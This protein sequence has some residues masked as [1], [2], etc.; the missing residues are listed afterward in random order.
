MTLQP[1]P[2]MTRLLR[3]HAVPFCDAPA[4]EGAGASRSPL[5]SGALRDRVLHVA[6]TLAGILRP[7]PLPTAGT[8][9]WRRGPP[10]WP[11]GVA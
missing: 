2:D 5:L 1:A 8:H 7:R 3:A 9:S 11:S 6:G 10:A 4:D